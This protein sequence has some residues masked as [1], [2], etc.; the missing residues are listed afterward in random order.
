MQPPRRYFGGR[1]RPGVRQLLEAAQLPSL[2]ELIGRDAADLEP[3]HQALAFAL[4][5]YLSQPTAAPITPGPIES[6]RQLPRIVRA[7]K[8]GGA[9]ADALR[10]ATGLEAEALDLRLRDWVKETYPR[11]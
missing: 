8:T 7:A 2:T 3:R 4:V 11:R 1:W 5:D 9:P 10:A 6:R